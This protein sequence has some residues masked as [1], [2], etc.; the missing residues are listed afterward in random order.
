[1]FGGDQKTQVSPPRGSSGRFVVIFTP[2]RQK[3]GEVIAIHPKPCLRHGPGHDSSYMPLCAPENIQTRNSLSTTKKA[4]FGFWAFK[5]V[6]KTRFFPY[7]ESAFFSQIK[8]ALFG[9]KEAS[10]LVQKRFF[11]FRLKKKVKKVKPA[12]QTPGKR[13]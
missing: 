1:M 7:I 9:A 10:S 12:F 11:F 5:F 6:F 13:N 8:K 4:L 3:A 2:K